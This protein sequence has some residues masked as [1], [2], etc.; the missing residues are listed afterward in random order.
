M[1]RSTT[2]FSH[3]AVN[4]LLFIVALGMLTPMT[5]MIITSLRAN[6]EQYGT[7]T[8]IL[9]AATTLENYRDAWQSDNFL[10][11]FMNS[12]LVASFVTAGNV[13]FCLWAGYAFAR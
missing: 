10:R 7:L 8:E 5:W 12:L 9:G 6:P 3:Y 2:A 1:N 11:Y 13:L 4:V